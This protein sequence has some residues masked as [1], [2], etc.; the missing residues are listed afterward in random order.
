MHSRIVGLALVMGWRIIGVGT[1][2][3]RVMVRE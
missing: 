2:V 3:E 1:V